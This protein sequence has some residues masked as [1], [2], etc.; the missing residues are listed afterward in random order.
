MIP[1]RRRRR[2][3]H[4][5]RVHQQRRSLPRRPPVQLRQRQPRPHRSRAS[6]PTR[7]PSR[8]PITPAGT[9][10]PHVQARTAASVVR[11]RARTPQASRAPT[12]VA[13]A[14]EARLHPLRMP[15]S[16]AATAAVPTMRRSREPMRPS[17]RHVRATTRSAVS[18]ACTHP[19]RE[20]SR[21]RIRWHVRRSITTNA[22]AE[23]MVDRVSVEA[24]AHVRAKAAA[25]P[26][27]RVPGVSIVRV[28]AAVAAAR[29][30]TVSVVATAATT[31]RTMVPATVHRA[32]AAVVAAAQPA[33]SAVR[34]ASPRRLART[35]WRSVTNTKS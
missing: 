15:L 10:R 25:V 26:R 34:A 5:S 28:Q 3:P 14:T 11:L 6:A 12:P 23:A 35:V 32:V 2:A 9:S 18:R 1:G 24:S 13:L 30:V 4:P 19:R 29:V 31:S 7:A 22:V 33:P 27:S 21:V 17:M 16:T 8:A 20:T